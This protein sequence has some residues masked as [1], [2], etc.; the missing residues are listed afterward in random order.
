MQFKF[1][2][3]FPK[4]TRLVCSSAAAE[5][6][7][8]AVVGNVTLVGTTPEEFVLNS[9]VILVFTEVLASVF[10]T[11]SGGAV[12]PSSVSVLSV[13]GCNSTAPCAIS[14]STGGFVS[15]VQSVTIRWSVSFPHSVPS[16]SV[17][18]TATLVGN[19]QL[20]L[21]QSLSPLLPTT[22]ST[23]VL[24]VRAVCVG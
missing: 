4:P 24:L 22:C 19:V 10:S 12:D 21:Q 2:A 18:Q 16:L 20:V 13:T 7:P 5:L 8:V 23:S 9:E 15:L 14:L 1:V 17:A 3:L 6:Q 11:Y